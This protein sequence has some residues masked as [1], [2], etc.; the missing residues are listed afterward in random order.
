MTSSMDRLLTLESAAQVL[1]LSPAT[2]RRWLRQG[3]IRSHELLLPASVAHLSKFP[4]GVLPVAYFRP[5]EILTDLS[6]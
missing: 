1:E 5:R 6:A 4:G 3:R 2:L